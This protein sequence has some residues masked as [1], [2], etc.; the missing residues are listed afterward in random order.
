MQLLNKEY[1]KA[2][3]KDEKKYEDYELKNHIYSYLINKGF[4]KDFGFTGWVE[5][6]VLY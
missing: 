5:T 1:L 2:K 3:N 6:K 4:K